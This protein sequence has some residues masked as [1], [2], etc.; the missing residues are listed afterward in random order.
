MR[1]ESWM[2]HDER[3]DEPT[4]AVRCTPPDPGRDGYHWVRRYR[5]APAIPLYWNAI[6]ASNTGSGWGQWQEPDREDQW[7]YLGPCPSPDDVARPTP[8]AEGG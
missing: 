2:A 1:W 8:A 4:P 6:W 5:G 3:K 7:E